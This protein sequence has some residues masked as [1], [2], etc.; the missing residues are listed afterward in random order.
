MNQKIKVYK[1][2]FFVILIVCGNVSTVGSLIVTFISTEIKTCPS[3]NQTVTEL[4]QTIVWPE[5]LK[6]EYTASDPICLD[7]TFRVV[8]RQCEEND[9]GSEPDCPKIQHQINP[10]PPGLTS[11]KSRYCIE[12][13]KETTF[14][15]N[16]K[17][18]NRIPWDDVVQ[19]F[20]FSVPVWM[21]VRRNVS[22]QLGI[23]VYRYIE[24][25]YKYKIPYQ[26][27]TDS[28]KTL[29]YNGTFT[30]KECLIYHNTSYVEAVSCDDKYTGICVYD[31]VPHQKTSLCQN[32]QPGCQPGDFQGNSVCFCETESRM[33]G[34]QVLAE[35]LSPYQNLLFTNSCRIGLQNRMESDTPFIWHNS[36]TPLNYSYWSPEVEYNNQFGVFTSRGWIL[37]ESSDTPCSFYELSI[38]PEEG[39]IELAEEDSYSTLYLRI[40]KYKNFLFGEDEKPQAYCFTNSGAKTIIAPIENFTTT[41]NTSDTDYMITFNGLDLDQSGP[42]YYWCEAFLY[43]DL[44]IVSSKVILLK[45]F[46]AEYVAIF[47]MKN[48]EHKL[49]SFPLTPENLETLQNLFRNEIPSTTTFYPRIFKINAIDEEK[50]ELNITFHLTSS[51]ATG[52]SEEFELLRN[53]AK[54]Q[55]LFSFLDFRKVDYCP[56]ITTWHMGTNINWPGVKIGSKTHPSTGY[57]VTFNVTLI[58]KSCTGNF[59]DGAYWVDVKDLCQFYPKS[60]VTEDLLDISSKTDDDQFE[61]A[62]NRLLTKVK[63]YFN[64]FNTLDLVITVNFLRDISLKKPNI[65]TFSGVINSLMD[66]QRIVLVSAQLN[67]KST[68]ILLQIID[69]TLKNGDFEESK[70]SNFAVKLINVAEYNARGIQIYNCT[71]NKNCNIRIS[72]SSSILSQEDAVAAVVLSDELYNQIITYSQTNASYI[73]KL[74]L[75]VYYGSN[76]FIELDSTKSS[77]LV[78]GIQL[79][80]FPETFEG[81]ISIYYYANINAYSTLY[82]CSYWQFNL[83]ESGSWVIEDTQRIN[84]AVACNFYHLTNFRTPFIVESIVENETIH[85]VNITT[86]DP[87]KNTYLGKFLNRFCVTNNFTFISEDF[88]L[89]PS[90]SVKMVLGQLKNTGVSG[91]TINDILEL[92][93]IMTK[94][95]KSLSKF[96][97]FVVMGFMEELN[98]ITGNETVNL[99]QLIGVMDNIMKVPAATIYE[100]QKRFKFV[101]TLID[102]VEQTI[103]K[104][105]VGHQ[106]GCNFAIKILEITKNISGLTL[107][108]CSVNLTYCVMN[109]SQWLQGYENF[110]TI[111]TI[112]MLSP[113]LHNQ[114]LNYAKKNYANYHPKM[115]VSL[116]LPSNLFI[117]S[118][119]VT[120]NPKL[121]FSILLP[122]FN[123]TFKGPVTIMYTK[124]VAT[125]KYNCSYWKY[126]ST[127][128]GYWEVES[129]NTKDQHVVCEFYHLTTFA[130]SLMQPSASTNNHALQTYLGDMPE[131]HFMNYVNLQ[132]KAFSH[133]ATNSLYLSS[134]MCFVNFVTSAFNLEQDTT[135]FYRNK[136]LSNPYFLEPSL[137]Q[138]NSIFFLNE[139][140][141][142]E[143]FLQILKTMPLSIFTLDTLADLVN[144][145]MNL[146]PQELF[147]AQM[148]YKAADEILYHIDKIFKTFDDTNEARRENVLFV[149][150]SKKDASHFYGISIDEYQ[151]VVCILNEEELNADNSF[152]VSISPKLHQQIRDANTQIVIA[153]FF[154]H[155]LFPSKENLDPKLPIVEVLIPNIKET[156]Q[157][158]ILIKYKDAIKGAC[159]YW[160][161]HIK[162]SKPG[163]WNQ[164][165]ESSVYS[166]STV[167]K[168]NHVTH[169]A[170]VASMHNITTDLEE[171]LASNLTSIE[172]ITQIDAITSSNH[173]NLVA[174]DIFLISQILTGTLYDG[175]FPGLTTRI[176]SN[177]FKVPREVL[178][179]SQ[180]IH[181]ATDII[182]YC[183]DEIARLLDNSENHQHNFSLIVKNLENTNVT[184]I[185][186][187][188]CETDICS[189]ELLDYYVDVAN[190]SSNETVSA[191]VLFDKGLVEQIRNLTKNTTIA[192]SLFY[193]DALFNEISLERNTSKIF[194]I[195]FPGL[196]NSSNLEGNVSVIYNVGTK[197]TKDSNQCA[198][199]YYH[200]DPSGDSGNGTPGEW[201]KDN[202]KRRKNKM[203]ICSYTHVTHFGMLLANDNELDDDPILDLITSI[204]CGLSIFGIIVIL[205]TAMLFKKWRRNTGNII[206]MNFA[207][208]ISLKII[209]LYTSVYVRNYA[210][211]MISCTIIGVILHYAILSECTW[212]L[213][214]AILQFKRFVEV[215]GGP[216]KYVLIKALICGWVFPLIPVICIVCI[217]P[218]NYEKGLANVCYPSNLGLYL[219]VWL[220]ILMILTINGIIFIF[221]IYN[222]F[223]KKTECIDT[224]HDILF[225]W[226]LTLLLFFMLGLNWGFGFL[227]QIKGDVLFTYLYTITA[228]LQGFILFLFFIVF[229][230]STR[231]LYTQS[232]KQW[233]YARGIFKVWQ[234]DKS[235]SSSKN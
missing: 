175:P 70:H 50:K 6:N 11:H 55:I 25:T 118:D 56:N 193:N 75:S 157:G 63:E 147:K 20:K 9:W 107:S 79:P 80:D 206:L 150:V 91:L 166:N 110:T 204:G 167:C 231:F 176:I 43:P 39:I 154:K 229:N 195:I 108:N 68:D 71:D 97:L 44:K 88:I 60:E 170:L 184:G 230:K 2:I 164:E 221:I 24:P 27:C 133:I 156:L 217:D 200:P 47:K 227:G 54:S 129:S 228:S 99:T 23:D 113:V 32:L 57:C 140:N 192:I 213:T 197:S 65:E 135:S 112:I 214:V 198:Y 78:F 224:N 62:L 102:T 196:V 205:L 16:C 103:I 159:S 207:V 34:D 3:V 178:R 146:D 153:I 190:Y 52:S 128:K 117:S 136:S 149:T 119:N 19:I 77:T 35:F 82:N 111:D 8:K 46:K 143:G 137:F 48:Y 14:P 29:F 189:I 4:N 201:M 96:D 185:I 218:K 76:L 45:N 131:K 134:K 148:S 36:L 182:L 151:E 180:E 12:T 58:Q 171:I 114:I 104:A 181:S 115:A 165:V 89:T 123:E 161:Y 132:R 220:P 124:N 155:V 130:I 83:T 191:M 41:Q 7:N 15:P 93:N 13:V 234:S 81:P 235:K 30:D 222:V 64:V 215:L 31:A 18:A 85:K 232:V 141:T 95:Y 40:S 90:K 212:M 211:Y 138:Q 69:Q 225:Q 173:N 209:A 233:F 73:P 199:W 139:A 188:D 121:V 37:A 101:D 84:E 163:Y 208:A 152:I 67:F 120:S 21:P 168:F 203:A 160:N 28:C 38:S 22:D 61:D 26:L 1:S 177:L 144:S 127:L 179:E 53:I 162:S 142:I 122:G 126:N 158:N 169:F 183:I 219:G 210:T 5:T 187:H 87:C 202:N 72:E 216:P 194:G 223:H 116:Y 86:K 74:I 109:D 145:I 94:S 17:Y 106:S 226:R 33:V 125:V 98:N 174:I 186:V 66:I 172:K 100:A 105:D 92:V 42:G 49:S 51:E 59:I 10:C